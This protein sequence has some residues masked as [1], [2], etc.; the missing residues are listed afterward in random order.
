MTE[1]KAQKRSRLNCIYKWLKKLENDLPKFELVPF[2]EQNKLK[3]SIQ[4]HKKDLLTCLL[5]RITFN[6][7]RSIRSAIYLDKG[8]VNTP[9]ENYILMILSQNKAL[10]RN[11]NWLKSFRMPYIRT[12]NANSITGEISL[13]LCSLLITSL[14]FFFL[15][16]V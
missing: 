15:S 7:S 2:V 9:S 14:I 13:L 5:R 1:L 3:S 12:L 11:W 10:K 16:I 4:Y 8:I 6:K